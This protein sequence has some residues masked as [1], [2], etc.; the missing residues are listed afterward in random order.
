VSYWRSKAIA[1]LLVTITSVSGLIAWSGSAAANGNAGYHCN[2]PSGDDTYW[3]AWYTNSV[4]PPADPRRA[5]SIDARGNGDGVVCQLE[6]LNP[7]KWTA[8]LKDNTA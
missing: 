4:Q 5:A 2:F 3:D 6:H 8:R 7:Q 1:L